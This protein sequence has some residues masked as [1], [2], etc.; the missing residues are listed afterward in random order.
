MPFAICVSFFREMSISSVHFF[1]CFFLLLL[2]QHC[3]SCLYILDIKT[4]VS[5]IIYKYFLP[6]CR[7]SFHFVDG[8][9][10][11]TKAFKF[12]QVP[13][14]CFYFHY[15]RRWSQKDIVIYVKESPGL[16]LYY[17]LIFSST[18]FIVTSLIFRYLIYFEFI[19]VY[20]VRECS[21]F[22]PLHVAFQF[23]QHYLQKRLSFL[24][25]V[26]LPPLLQIQFSSVAQSCA[27]L[28]NPMNRST[29]GLPVHHQLP[30]FT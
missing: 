18:S 21:N 6:F 7:L 27:T 30:E 4:H 22:I 26:F 3:I 25:C 23:S 1:D 9:L 5:R 8:L 14:A 10:C 15:C 24:H 13:F 16:I 2:L 28:C 19:F 12:N 11:C 20:G 17:S 29:P